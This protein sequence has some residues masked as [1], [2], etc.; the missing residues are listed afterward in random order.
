MKKSF[1]YTVILVA[2]FSLSST[3]YSQ[4]AICKLNPTE[5]NKVTGTIT[6]TKTADGVRI[7]ADV[8]G[9]SKGKHGFHIHEFG[10]CSS[11]D[12]SSAGGHFNPHSKDH[13]APHDTDRHSGDMGNIDANE[14]GVGHLEYVDKTISLTGDD[15]IIGKSVIVHA[16]EDDLKSQ[17]TGNAG[18]R[19]AC[20]I[21][22]SL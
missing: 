15:S 20:G 1:L 4:T 22:E 12:G 19:I 17:P 11:K 16:N 9:L 18:G 10:D 6:F 8:E 13:G 14:K 7:V 2:A 5:G 3:V 21:I